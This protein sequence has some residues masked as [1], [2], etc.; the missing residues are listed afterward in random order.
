M[1]VRASWALCRAGAQHTGDPD[2]AFRELLSLAHQHPVQ[3]ALA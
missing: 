1:L 2:L 3:A